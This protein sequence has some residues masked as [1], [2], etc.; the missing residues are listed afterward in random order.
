MRIFSRS[1]RINTQNKIQNMFVRVNSPLF[2][3][4]LYVIKAYVQVE[5]QLHAFLTAAV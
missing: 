1:F 5:L 3:I 4:T 2:Y